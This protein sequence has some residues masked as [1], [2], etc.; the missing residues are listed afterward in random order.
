[1]E[2]RTPTAGAQYHWT[3][4]LAPRAPVFLSLMQGWITVFAWLATTATA[5]YIVATEIQGVVILNYPTYTPQGWHSALMM[6]AVLAVPVIINIYARRLLAPV[7][8]MGGICHLMFLP[9]ILVTL[10]CLAPRSEA[11]FVFTE[12]VSGLSGWSN[13]GVVWSL[14]LLAVV[15]PLTGKVFW[16]KAYLG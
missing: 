5:P 4:D 9:A 14:G 15:F 7:E 3:F 8:I 6:W 2:L 1:M 11:S 12:F 13:D 16:R 10:I